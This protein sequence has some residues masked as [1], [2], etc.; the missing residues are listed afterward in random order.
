[1]SQPLPTQLVRL[2][3]NAIPAGQARYLGITSGASPV[4]ELQAGATAPTAPTTGTGVTPPDDAFSRQVWELV[5][6]PYG[7]MGLKAVKGTRS[8]YLNGHTLNGAVDLTAS[9]AL[10][11][12]GIAWDYVDS[13]GDTIQLACRGNLVNANFVRL[14]VSAQGGLVLVPDATSASTQWTIERVPFLAYPA[15]LEPQPTGW[16]LEDH[17]IDVITN[18][19]ATCV[20]TTPSAV[21][22]TPC[23]Q[24]P[25]N[26]IPSYQGSTAY[27]LC[28]WYIVWYRNLLS[29]VRSSPRDVDIAL[30]GDSI[31]MF[32][33]GFIS[34]P[35][36]GLPL[37][38]PWTDCFGDTT[39]INLGYA[40][41][42][43]QSLLWRLDHGLL[44]GGSGVPIRPKL[45]ILLIG[46]N[47]IW[48]QNAQFNAD[49]TRAEAAG[50][51]AQ[52][53]QLCVQNLCE[54]CPGAKIALIQ[55]LPR[56]DTPAN[57]LSTLAIRD[58]VTRLNLPS[59]W[60][61]VHV[62]DLSECFP[63]DQAA[64][65]FNDG[66]HPSPAGYVAYFQKL[67]AL[68]DA[69]HLLPS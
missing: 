33:N 11:Y 65:L 37:I 30:V 57:T 52:G 53:I 23:P 67:H 1:M 41:D 17:E 12:T 38:P 47:D 48:Y 61:Q 45:I 64:T 29:H 24:S 54:R 5:P 6:T 49:S 50:W 3:S 56:Y 62:F 27:S 43:T 58:A 46:T 7:H 32:L 20:P 35:T 59:I 40:A 60:P 2:A 66:L 10:P 8:L 51:A 21:A 31:T 16:P 18:A 69:Q 63:A 28:N 15:Q 4:V 42:G 25:S 55:V 14:A 44:D 26:G 36:P 39:T 68:L 22:S 13:T 9:T 19:W 34:G